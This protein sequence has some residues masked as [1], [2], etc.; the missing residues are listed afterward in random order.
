MERANKKIGVTLLRYNVDKP[1]S[2]YAQVRFFARKK[3][4]ENFQ[5]ILYVNNKLG[6]LIY[7]LHVLNF[8]FDKVF[9]NQPICNIL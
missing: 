2:S 8:V 5:Q 4:D 9:T 1:E 3:E 7:L 6:E